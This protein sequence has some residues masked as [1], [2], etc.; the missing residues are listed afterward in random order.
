M[1][2]TTTEIA[3]NRYAPAGAGD[4]NLYNRGE[5]SG[6]TIGQLVIS[7]C[8]HAAAAYEDQ[9]VLKMNAMTAGSAKLAEA[10]SWME[11]I[12]D[13]AHASEWPAAKAFLTGT[14]GIPESSLPDNLST[15]AKRMQAAKA[16]KEK[17]DILSQ[18]QQQDMIDLQTLVNRRDVAYSTSSNITRTFGQSSSAK[19]VNF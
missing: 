19:A 7:V 17:I 6:L 13:E 9:S 11:R 8:L 10:S 2:I 18:T 12:V 5:A 15:Y 16:L 14:M 4:I 1:G 3:V